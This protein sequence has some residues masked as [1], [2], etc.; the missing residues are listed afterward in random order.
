MRGDS[1]DLRTGD[2]TKDRPLVGRGLHT[3]KR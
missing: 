1:E 2:G 3:V